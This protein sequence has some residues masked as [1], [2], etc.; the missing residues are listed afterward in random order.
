M[1]LYAVT[2]GTS[3]LPLEEQVKLAIGGGIT[4][5]QLR[6]KNLCGAPLAELA[7]K[8]I[9]LCRRAGIP[10]VLDDDVEAAL[11]S[12]ADGVHVGQSDMV[13]ES[14]RK[15][16]GPGKIIGVSAHTVEEALA[17]ERGGADYL[18]V[19]AMF[20]TATKSDA[21]IVSFETLLAI[22]GAVKI[23][24]VAIGGINGSNLEQFRNSGADGAAIV[25][26]IFSQPDILSATRTLRAQAEKIF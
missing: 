24:V 14:A 22:C 13:L 7:K 21:E 16:L 5:L 2:G 12:G 20:A 17:A 10:F 11:E 18:G 1:L 4:F 9:P 19:G 8:L 25:S 6:E 26:A 15:I 23:P 3:P